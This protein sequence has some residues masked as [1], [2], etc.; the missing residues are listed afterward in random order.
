MDAAQIIVIDGDTVALGRQRIRLQ[1]F[2]TP[3]TFDAKCPA[4]YAKGV[5]ARERLK[6]LMASGKVDLVF[7]HRHDRY[8]REIARLLVD[9]ED[10]AAIMIQEELAVKFPLGHKPDWCHGKVR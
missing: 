6:E 10:I 8:G 3:E 7:S 5:E 2:D 1:G 9:G 4:E